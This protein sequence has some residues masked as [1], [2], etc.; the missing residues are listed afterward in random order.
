MLFTAS[1]VHP[2]FVGSATV[3][4]QILQP[5]LT[6]SAV[7]EAHWLDSTLKRSPWLRVPAELALQT[8]DFKADREAFA[9]DLISTGRMNPLRAHSIADVAVR[10]AYTQ[11]IP[12]ALVLGVMLTENDEFKSHARSRWGAVGLM[13][14]YG[15]AWRRALGRRYGRDLHD[16]ATNLRY[17]IFILRHMTEEIPDSLGADDAWRK[18]LLRYNGCV[19]ASTCSRYPDVV[20]AHVQNAATASCRGQDFRS[21]VVKPLWVALRSNAA[22]GVN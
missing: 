12:P 14:V 18:A 20:Q 22:N 4:R 3:A 1:Q 15:K 6:D 5:E 7:A 8:E 2:V 10:E 19:H 9:L 21:C 13:Q 16:D 11:R 17:G